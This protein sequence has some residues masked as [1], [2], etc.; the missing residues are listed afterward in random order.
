[1][2]PE[3]LTTAVSVFDG[4]IG[5]TPELVDF[6][7]S[8]VIVNGLSVNSP[9]PEKRGATFS[10]PANWCRLG[11]SGFA[12]RA[13]AAASAST[14]TAR[15]NEGILPAPFGAGASDLSVLG[16]QIH[17]EDLERGAINHAL[18]VLLPDTARSRFVWPAD[19]TD[20]MSGETDAIPEGTRFRLSPRLRLGSL[21]LNA[22]A[23][24]IARSIQ[25][26]GMVVGNTSGVVALQAQDPTPQI[27]KGQ[28]NPYRALL[29]PDPYHVLDRIP[30]RRLEVLRP[31]STG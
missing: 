30:G 15:A 4:N 22:S 3:Y 27:S 25:R 13:G 5:V 6:S 20:G 29:R 31:V 16:G 19:P 1:V 26:Y 28:P 17:L 23:L 11:G 14:P 9:S 8:Q 12:A 21:H 10:L 24:A 18:E 7:F 2:Q